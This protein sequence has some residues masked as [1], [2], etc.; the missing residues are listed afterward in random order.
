MLK[1]SEAEV[2]LWVID[3]IRAGLVS[4]KLSQVNQSFRVYRSAHRTFGQ[5]QW[6]ALETRLVQWQTSINNIL[7]TIASE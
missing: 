7:E 3:V 1:I 4:G 5:E 2:E 6:K